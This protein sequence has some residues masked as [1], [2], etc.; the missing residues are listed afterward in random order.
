MTLFFRTC[1]NMKTSFVECI[2]QPFD[3]A[4]NTV[5]TIAILQHT[6]INDKAKTIYANNNK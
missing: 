5:V 6:K 3:Q 4:E 1:K 2:V